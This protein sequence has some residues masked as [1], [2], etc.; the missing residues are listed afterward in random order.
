VGKFDED[1]VLAMGATAIGCIGIKLLLI[2]TG[3]AVFFE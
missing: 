1:V 3:S 2:A